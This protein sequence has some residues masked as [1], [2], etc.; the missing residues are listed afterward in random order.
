MLLHKSLADDS[1]VSRGI[2]VP[3]VFHFYLVGTVVFG[4][5]YP[6]LFK[7]VDPHKGVRLVASA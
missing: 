6:Q 3:M 4:S 5:M 7:S 2:Q 1:S